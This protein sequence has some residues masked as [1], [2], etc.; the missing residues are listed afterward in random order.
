MSTAATE[1]KHRENIFTVDKNENTHEEKSRVALDS[2]RKLNQEAQCLGYMATI[3]S[4]LIE[5]IQSLRLS[6]DYLSC[7]YIPVY[8]VR[9]TRQS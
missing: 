5:I 8:L 9:E 6:M 1:L 7:S 4:I 3:T 2:S